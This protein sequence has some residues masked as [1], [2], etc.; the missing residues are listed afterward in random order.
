MVRMDNL[1]A[2]TV[3]SWFFS[4]ALTAFIGFIQRR[5]STYMCDGFF[6]HVL[7][8]TGVLLSGGGWY[9]GGRVGVTVMG[10]SN[11]VGVT[12]VELGARLEFLG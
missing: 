11:T 1:S 5:L 3:T 2:A 9:Y 10:S 12:S 4:G 6:S 8:Q 7:N